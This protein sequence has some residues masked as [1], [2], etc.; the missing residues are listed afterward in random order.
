[1][2]D[3]IGIK[4]RHWERFDEWS[5]AI[6]C[7]SIG[8]VNRRFLHDE[9]VFPSFDRPSSMDIPEEFIVTQLLGNIDVN[10]F[11]TRIKIKDTPFFRKEQDG[12][13]I[14]LYRNYQTSTLNPEN[15]KWFGLKNSI[16][17]TS[18]QSV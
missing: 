9:S 2:E 12:K 13:I 5:A 11:Y 10:E 16:V 1:M 4:H 3:P 18:L 8:R 6:S 14:F 15:R 17:N 7:L